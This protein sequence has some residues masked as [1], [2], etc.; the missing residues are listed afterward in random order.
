MCEKKLKDFVATHTHFHS[1]DR[2]K[3]T[4]GLQCGFPCPYI[5]TNEN[6]VKKYHWSTIILRKV[7]GVDRVGA[8]VPRN[9]G[10]VRAGAA[11]YGFIVDRASG[12]MHGYTF[13]SHVHMT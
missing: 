9:L 5:L 1:H 4:L 13:A 3:G 6:K 7:K 2:S 8:G 10:V 12:V 11:G